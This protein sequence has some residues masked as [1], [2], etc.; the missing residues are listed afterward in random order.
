[1]IKDYDVLRIILLVIRTKD[2]DVLKNKNKI[3]RCVK[4]FA[5]ICNFAIYFCKGLFPQFGTP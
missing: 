5:I 2:Y 3:V 4:A 1:M